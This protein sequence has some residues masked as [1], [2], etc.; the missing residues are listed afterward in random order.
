VCDIGHIRE[1]SAQQQQAC[2]LGQHYHVPSFPQT[3]IYLALVVH[4]NMH[5]Q[6]LHTLAP[7]G[8]RV[9]S[10]GVIV[11]EEYLIYPN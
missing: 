3:Y 4:W 10:L 6:Y 11:V 9:A 5:H 1:I 2:E 8:N 7:V